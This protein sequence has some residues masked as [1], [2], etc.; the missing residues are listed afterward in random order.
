VARHARLSSPH[1]AGQ[2]A[3]LVAVALIVLLVSGVGTGAF[4]FWETTQT[5]ADNSVK[6]EDEKQLPP[7]IGEIEGG[8]NLLLVGTDSCKGQS[9]KLFPRCK[10]DPGGERNDVTMLVHIGDDPR[11]VTVVSFPRD[12]LVPIPS[13]PDGKGGHYDAMSSQMLNSSYMYGGLAC[14]VLT[15]EKLS[16]LD[17]QFA[18]AIR[19]TGVINMSDAIGG[20]DVCVSGEIDDRNTGLHLKAGTHNLKGNKALQFL[21]IRHGIG[22]GSDLGRISNQQ[23]FLSS[24]IRKLQSGAVLSNPS[25]LFGL[26]NTAV[27]QVSKKQL[28]LS[29]SLSNPTRMVQIAMAVKDV[30]YKDIV[31]LQYPTAYEQGRGASKVVPRTGPAK[32]LFQALKDNKAIKLTGKTSQGFGVEVKGE[33]SKPTTAP[34]PGTSGSPTTTPTTPPVDPDADAVEL[35]S[36]IAGQTAAQVTCTLPQR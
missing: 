21:R 36:A 13:C 3:K 6:L 18:G 22:D 17:I 20:V 27:Q 33:A 16:G 29:D 11:R 4:A 30:D 19:W 14:T 7:S 28:V 5:I 2:I 9:T 25:T 26:A 10:H 34:T 12:M 31:F 1:P 15:V 8:V 24:M 35:P 23:Q 32:V